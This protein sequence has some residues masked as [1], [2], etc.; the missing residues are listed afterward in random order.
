MLQRLSSIVLLALMGLGASECTTYP[1]DGSMSPTDG[2]AQTILFEGCAH[3]P[4]RGYLFCEV[5]EGSTAD[6][7]VTI[8][9]PGDTVCAR[10]TG[11]GEFEVIRGG[12][13]VHSG[14]IALGDSEIHFKLSDLVHSDIIKWDHDDEYQVL[15]RVF[16]MNGKKEFS[17]SM[18]G[19]IR[20]WVTNKQYK[21]LNCNSPDAVFKNESKEGFEFQ[22]STKMRT[23]ICESAP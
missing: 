3:D 14:A 18:S 8:Y 2:R 9:V 5:L 15:I 20:I 21:H 4:T 11:C 12:N 6:S 19:P 13:I 23:A 16:F 10:A 22:Y 7:V 1:K 17:A